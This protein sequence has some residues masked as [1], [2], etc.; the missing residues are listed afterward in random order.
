MQTGAGKTDLRNHNVGIT[1][2]YRAQ[3]VQTKG[4]RTA[5][6]TER[7]KRRRP[8]DVTVETFLYQS[9]RTNGKNSSAKANE[10][11]KVGKRPPGNLFWH[12]DTHRVDVVCRTKPKGPQL[13]KKTKGS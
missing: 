2:R 7:R 9:R 11:G 8:I 4:K 6:K 1:K 10:A 12:P 3:L 13:T 5:S